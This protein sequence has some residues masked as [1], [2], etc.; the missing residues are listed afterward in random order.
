MRTPKNFYPE[1]INFKPMTETFNGDEEMVERSFPRAKP[2]GRVIVPKEVIE[3]TVADPFG[4]PVVEQ[5]DVVV[6]APKVVAD[7]PE[8]APN[9]AEDVYK[10]EVPVVET[11]EVAIEDIP[12][13]ETV[14]PIEEE[15]EEVAEML[16][17]PTVDAT[18]AT[19]IEGLG[20]EKGTISILHKAGLSTID[21]L[22]GYWN[23]NKSFEPIKGIGAK[24]AVIIEEQ[25]AVLG[26][27]LN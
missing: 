17:E 18:G 24:T 22:V 8:V 11:V 15:T 5:P 10:E 9:I 1:P 25:L 13:V 12:V 16:P 7:P 23:E 20:L 4:V 19:R 14:A 3:P 6:P 2:P 26:V 27:V 21:D